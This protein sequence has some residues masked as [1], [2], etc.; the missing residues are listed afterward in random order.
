MSG[1]EIVYPATGV[2]IKRV[3]VACWLVIV[4]REIVSNSRQPHITVHQLWA[5]WLTAQ[6]PHVLGPTQP[7]TSQEGEWVAA[8]HCGLLIDRGRIS[9][10][11]VMLAFRPGI[12]IA[13][14][15]TLHYW[16]TWLFTWIR[17]DYFRLFYQLQLNWRK[18]W[19]AYCVVMLFS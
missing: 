5:S 19:L 17:F 8:Y 7:A 15:I 9:N 16:P 3:H 1:A 13:H 6:Y 4:P 10:I 11:L 18:C 12:E 14:Y 2:D